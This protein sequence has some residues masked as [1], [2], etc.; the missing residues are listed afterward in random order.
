MV[1]N[2]VHAMVLINSSYLSLYFFKN[3]TQN[4]ET[5][6]GKYCEIG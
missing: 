4:T 5:Y 3:F 2:I 6:S 1:V